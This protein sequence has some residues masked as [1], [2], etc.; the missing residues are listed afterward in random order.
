MNLSNIM[1]ALTLLLAATLNACGKDGTRQAPQAKAAE[2]RSDK[3]GQEGEKKEGGHEAGSS[4]KLTQE[5]IAAAGIKVETLQLQNLADRI[6]VTATIQ[7]NQDKLAHV[8]PRIPGRIVQVNANLGDA[9]KPGLPLA[10]LDSLELGEARAAYVQAKSKTA[11]AR[12]AFERA[13][14]LQ[15][16]KI[17]PEKDYLRA[18]YDHEKAKAQLRT[19]ADK[20]RLLG[21]DPNSAADGKASSTFPLTSPNSGTVIEKHAV[22]GDLAKTDESLFTVADLSVLWIEA[23]LFEKD[24][25]RVKTGAD[26]EV[27]V[28]AY[29]E[30]VF[31]GKLTYISSVL[32]KETRT[33]KARIEVPNPDR[34]L[35]PNM[36]AI[37][38]IATTSQAEALAVPQQALLL[39]S[40]EPNVFIE[41]DG[42]FEPRT[43]KPGE[44]SGGMVVIASGLEPGAKV[45]VDGA[46]ALKARLLKSTLGEGH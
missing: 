46:F 15:A 18:K 7:A 14:R 17:I 42:A 4:V 6:E 29:P 19:A 34:K 10:L 22:L 40:G 5:E 41:K 33:L 8:A 31:K 20:L 27:T 1:L 28:T 3:T 36:F 26:A 9:V 44:R 11:L 24:L 16:E 21:V 39:M 30:Q 25:G 23:A 12:S 37:A 32:D 43:V 45:V 2:S 35:K 13:E 38:H